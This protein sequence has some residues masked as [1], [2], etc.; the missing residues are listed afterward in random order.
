MPL[1]ITAHREH[2]AHALCVPERDV[3][4]PGY[5]YV[6]EAATNVFHSERVRAPKVTDLDYRRPSR[7]M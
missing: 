6:C 2:N 7:N 3:Q 4:S 1:P 5:N